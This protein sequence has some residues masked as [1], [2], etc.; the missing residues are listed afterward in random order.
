MVRIS[1]ACLLLA[2]CLAQGETDVRRDA[3]VDAVQRVMPSV[4]NVATET[5]IQVR[6]PLEQLFRDFFDPYYRRRPPNTQHSLGS[7][8]IIDEEGYVLTNFHVVNRAS[9]VWVRLFDGREYECEKISGTSL[10]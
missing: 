1:L 3:V 5:V 4:V 9:R 2:A 8:V 6:D 7:G 10:A